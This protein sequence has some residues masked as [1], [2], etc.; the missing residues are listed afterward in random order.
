MWK[1]KEA[2]IEIARRSVVARTCG[3]GA[4]S[5]EARDIIEAPFAAEDRARSGSGGREG[6][7]MLVVACTACHV[8]TFYDAASLGLVHRI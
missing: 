1:R 4:T 5:I 6:L 2:W 3:C 8:F 7:P